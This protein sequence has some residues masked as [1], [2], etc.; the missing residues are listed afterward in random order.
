VIQVVGPRNFA[1]AHDTLLAALKRDPSNS[2]V[3]EFLWYLDKLVLNKDPA[4][5][6]KPIA[7]TPPAGLAADRQSALDAVNAYRKQAGAPAVTADPALAEAAEAH[8][9]YTIFN[10]G[11]P[12][13]SGLGIH[14]EDPKLPG[15]VAANFLQRDRAAGYQGTRAAEV[16]NHV[17]TPSAAVAVWVDS[18]YHRFPLLDRETQAIGYGEASIGVLSAA[19][20]DVGIGEPIKGQPVLFPADGARDVPAAFIGHEIPDPAPTGT[21]YPIGYPVTLVMG[22]A[23]AFLVESSR[24][25]AADGKEIPGFALLPGQ[26]VDRGEWSFLARDPLQPGATYTA[27]V[28]GTLDGQPFSR[29]WS[30]TVTGP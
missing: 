2:T 3:Y 4:A 22:T 8:A 7:P 25:L 9:W 5:E 12:S 13:E 24:L 27:E 28:V 16:I 19:V 30:F 20:M 1:A 26:Q 6:L 14:T 18:V 21:H 15:F 17:Y 29:R 11:Q 23:S 10:Y